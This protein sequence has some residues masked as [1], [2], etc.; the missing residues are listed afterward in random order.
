MS[1]V[2]YTNSRGSKQLRAK[3]RFIVAGGRLFPAPG[4]SNMSSNLPSR[5]VPFFP[6]EPVSPKVHI[7]IISPFNPDRSV[8]IVVSAR[9]IHPRERVWESSSVECIKDA[10]GIELVSE[11]DR[12]SRRDL[13]ERY[14]VSTSER[15]LEEFSEIIKVEPD[16]E[17]IPS[18]KPP[19]GVRKTRRTYHQQRE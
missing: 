1:I 9:D 2:D 3:P 5:L 18:W 6:P 13:F 12:V 10:T 11:P 14:V 17:T 15:I 8:H 4:L 19:V 7:E 16:A